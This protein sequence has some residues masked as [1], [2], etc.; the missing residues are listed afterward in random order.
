MIRAWISPSHSLPTIMFV[1]QF[2]TQ[3]MAIY[4]LEQTSG[5]STKMGN[6]RVRKFLFPCT[7]VHAKNSD[8]MKESKRSLMLSRTT[9]TGLIST[10]RSSCA[11][12]LRWCVP[13]EAFTR[14][15]HVLY[16]FNS[17]GV[18][19]VQTV[20]LYASQMKRLRSLWRA[21]ICF[22]SQTRSDSIQECSVRNRS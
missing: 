7:L 10:N 9:E 22:C 4:T 21:S 16:S 20:M 14:N 17:R 11:S 15:Q 5:A 8:S 1:S 2:W 6:S 13:E 12:I 3:N 19:I 18:W